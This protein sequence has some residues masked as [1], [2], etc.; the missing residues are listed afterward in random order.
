MK[1]SLLI[2]LICVVLAGWIGTLI[3]RDPGYVLIAYESY[4]F[5]TSLWI[6]LA[7]LVVV[8][9]GAYYLLRLLRLFVVGPANLKGWRTSRK[10]RR[11][12]DLTRK[13]LSLLAAGEYARAEKYLLSGAQ[14]HANPGTFYL[15]AAKAAD[16]QKNSEQREALLRMALEADDELS[17]AVAMST[18]E[19]AAGRGEWQ[20]SLKNLDKLPVTKA[21]LELKKHAL[22]ESGDWRGLLALMPALRTTKLVDDDFEKRIAMNHLSQVSL[23]DGGRTAVI[24]KLSSAVRYD[25]DIVLCYTRSLTDER[26]AEINLRKSIKRQWHEDYAKAYGKLGR[27]TLQTRIKHAESWLKK[28]AGSADLHMALATMYEK[29]GDLDKARAACQRSIDVSPT[30]T[31]VEMMATFLAEDGDHLASNRYLKQ[32]L[33]LGTLVDD[34]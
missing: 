5:Q 7:I 21:V 1:Y 16:G 23:T 33:T 28:H 10:V 19:M 2:V 34:G 4:R 8:V 15:A 32:A 6:M 30:R 17:T 9:V 13:G 12:D 25:P 24:K 29:A 26:A 3:A 14:D 18:A 11:A 31:A 27:D 20:H 22:Y